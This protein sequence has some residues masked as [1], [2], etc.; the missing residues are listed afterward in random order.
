MLNKFCLTNQLSNNKL[1]RF[2][3]E[4]ES[5]VV[6]INLLESFYKTDENPKDL[7]KKRYDICKSIDFYTTQIIDSDSTFHSEDNKK[8]NNT[9]FVLKN[10]Q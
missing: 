1:I 6:Y 5:S 4:N 8:R 9:E 3:Y 7:P 2:T 10:S